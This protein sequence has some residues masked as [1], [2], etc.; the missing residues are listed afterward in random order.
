MFWCVCHYHWRHSVAYKAANHQ[1]QLG[2]AY[3][4]ANILNL[5]ETIQIL[6]TEI[7]NRKFVWFLTFKNLTTTASIAAYLR[8]NDTDE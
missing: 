7:F 1:D 2:T 6:S 3:T 4:A 5:V 8:I